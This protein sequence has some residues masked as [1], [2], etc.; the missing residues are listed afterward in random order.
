MSQ[1]CLKKG[2]V[3]DIETFIKFYSCMVVE[4]GQKA[5]VFFLRTNVTKK[6]EHVQIIKLTYGVNWW[7]KKRDKIQLSF[8]LK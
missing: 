8:D 5:Q 4:I 6:T 3:K 2:S 1:S 7:R